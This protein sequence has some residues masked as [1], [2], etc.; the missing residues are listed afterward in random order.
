MVCGDKMNFPATGQDEIGVPE[1]T[2]D[3]PLGTGIFPVP[4][5]PWVGQ[6]QPGAE[7]R[8]DFKKMSKGR[9]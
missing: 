9:V 2:R 6:A 1:G 7:P 3:S 5:V 4:G 8:E